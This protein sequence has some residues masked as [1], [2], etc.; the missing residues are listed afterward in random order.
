MRTMTNQVPAFLLNPRSEPIT[1]YAGTEVATLEK[2]EIFAE[3]VSIVG[4]VNVPEAGEHM[5]D[6]LWG[7]AEKAGPGLMPSEKETFLSSCCITCRYIF[8]VDC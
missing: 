6:I 8:K 4:N 5:Q 3:T 2:V 7:L 1:L